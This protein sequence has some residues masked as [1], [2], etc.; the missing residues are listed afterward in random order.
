MLAADGKAELV[1][2]YGIEI[3]IMEEAITIVVLDII[4]IF[5]IIMEHFIHTP[6]DTI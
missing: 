2:K 1:I 5:H 3:I 4:P 6:K